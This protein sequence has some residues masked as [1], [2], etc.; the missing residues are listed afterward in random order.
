MQLSRRTFVKVGA[1]A[2]GSAAVAGLAGCGGQNGSSSDAST[3]SAQASA[4]SASAASSAASSGAG[5]KVTLGYWGGT[6]EMPIYVG[7][8]KGFFADAGLD[9]DIV[10]ITED[11][12]P[13]MAN[14]SLDCFELT[15]DKFKP[16]EQGLECV[17]IDSLHYGCQQGVASPESG[18]TSPLDLEG[19]N[20][21][22][23]M[24]SIAQIALSAQ[25]VDAGLDPSKVNWL[26]FQNAQM[27]DALASGEIDCF[28]AYDPW[29]D[30]SLSKDP[31]RVRFWSWTYDEP[32]KNTLCCFVGLS[33]RCMKENPDAAKMLAEGFKKSAE[34]IVA[35]PEEACDLAIDAGYVPINTDSGFTR[36]MMI[37]EV[38]DYRFISGDKAEIDKSFEDIWMMIAKAGAM[39]D[40]PSGDEALKTYINETLYNKMVDLPF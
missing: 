40:A 10:K 20:V 21:A 35:N 23:K 29:P 34:W 28:A 18:I 4:S 15:P 19:K 17:I 11:V 39:E 2:L 16:M 5:N 8:E 22:A 38:I 37:Q 13:L 30:I 33:T 24:G 27:D 1:V 31:N 12:A 14:G 7:Y 36:D 9:I 32:I 3:S 26:T 6:C 25:M